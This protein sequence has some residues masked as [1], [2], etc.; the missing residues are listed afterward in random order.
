MRAVRRSIPPDERTVRG[1]RV[2]ALVDGLPELEAAHSV[3]LFSSF[4]TEV[5]TGP[6][7]ERLRSRGRSVLLP[8]LAAEGMD[9]ASIAPGEPLV[10]T[11][12]GPR[13]PAR[14]VAADPAS[15]DIMILPGLAF[16]R[17]GHRLGYGGGHYD[18][19]GSRLRADA[20]RI[21]I[22]FHE[23]VVAKVPHGPG[24][25]PVNLVV[26]DREVIDCRPARAGR[27]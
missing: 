11:S 25:G 22:C 9:A 5:P 20:V 1:D 7:L 19:Y 13:E 16:D 26:T 2:A 12:Y 21:G 3:L 15:I 6:L 24:D 18:A 17:R 14:R 10:A 8:Y 23:Q 4:G 27:R